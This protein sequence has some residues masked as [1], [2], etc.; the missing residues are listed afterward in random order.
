MQHKKLF[1]VLL[2][3]LSYC[4]EAF[5]TISIRLLIEVS[6]P[7]PILYIPDVSFSTRLNIASTTSSIKIKSRIGFR[8]YIVSASFPESCL[9]IFESA[10]F[11][12]IPSPITLENR[13]TTPPEVRTF[14]SFSN[15]D[16]E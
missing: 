15:F 9:S 6:T 8:L 7:L 13:V 11:F 5:K 4:S 12:D 10:F 14:S 1:I 3:S 16:I 2:I